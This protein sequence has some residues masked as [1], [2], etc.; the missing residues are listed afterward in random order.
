[1]HGV[2]RD[3]QCAAEGCEKDAEREH[4]GEQP[5]LIDAE[6]R[7]HVAVLRRGAHQHAPARALEQQPEPAEHDWTKRNQEQI[8]ARDILAEKIDRAAETAGKAQD[9]LLQIN[10]GDEWQKSGVAPADVESA[11][12]QVRALKGLRLLGLMAI[13][14]IGAPEET[15]RH[16]RRLREIRDQIGLVHLSM[17]MSEDFEI[18]IEEGSTIV[19]IGRAIFGPRG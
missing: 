7:H 14:P 16:F 13:P 17:G 18:A 9:V 12:R 4:A 11:S 5:F 8:V 10:V 15:R 3:L 2:P 1:M 19:R 6:R